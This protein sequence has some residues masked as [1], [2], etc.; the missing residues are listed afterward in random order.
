MY[1]QPLGPGIGPREIAAVVEALDSFFGRE[2]RVLPRVP[3]PTEAY[4]AQRHRYRAEKLLRFLETRLPEGGYRILGVTAADI[5]TTTDS[6]RDW[7]M[8]GLAS[9]A[10]PVGVVSFFR[11]RAGV[12]AAA[13]RTRLTKVAVH[14]IGHTLGLPHCATPGCLMAD[15]RGRAETTD[16]GNDFC[17]ACRALLRSWNE[18]I[19]DETEIPWS[20][21]MAGGFRP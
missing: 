5:S 13:A 2:V 8:M 7:G 4:Y 19:P 10:D 6:A 11:C 17:S 18:E 21:R 15:A 3:L 20:L 1:I 14:E 16:A 9:Y 12:T